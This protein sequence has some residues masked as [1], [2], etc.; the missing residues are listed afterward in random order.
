MA[1]GETLGQRSTERFP[2]WRGGGRSLLGRWIQRSM[3][4]AFDPPL[5]GG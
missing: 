5:Q 3:A 1:Q 2:P 4:N